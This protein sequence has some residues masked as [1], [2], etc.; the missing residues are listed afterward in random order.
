LRASDLISIK[1]YTIETLSQKQGK[2]SNR[3]PNGKQVIDNASMFATSQNGKIS[4]PTVHK[5]QEKKQLNF[6]NAVLSQQL[7]KR[8]VDPNQNIIALMRM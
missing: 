7:Q 6:Q 1:S 4:V 5:L 8:K 2:P 3:L